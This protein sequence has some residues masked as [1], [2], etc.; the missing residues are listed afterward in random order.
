MIF[1]PTSKLISSWNQFL[2]ANG[3]L[4]KK[5]GVITTI[6][7]PTDAILNMVNFPGW[8]VVIVGDRKTPLPY[9]L[10][11]D[12]FVYLSVEIQSQL[13]A[14]DDLYK[15]LSTLT[16][17]NHFG[18]KN[19][20][21]LYAIDNGAQAVWDFDDD[22]VLLDNLTSIEGPAEGMEVDTSCLAHNIYP[23]MGAPTLPCWPR[24]FPL[25]DI[26]K[27]CTRSYHN[28]ST[29]KVGVFQSLANLEP[30][31]DAIFR[32]TQPSPFYFKS[33]GGDEI[34]LSTVIIPRGTFVP[35]NAQATLVMRDALWSLSLPV[36]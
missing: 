36:R 26:K 11:S 15:K 8:C 23:D 12:S 31:I 10:P 34:G 3:K 29:K 28:A 13:G 22:N 5:W 1:F 6:N 35:Y 9:D 16:P 20:G 17:W 7:K 30:D 24:G 19:F 18:R 4:R 2:L 33:K 21:Y 14:D 27:N 25:V 32:L